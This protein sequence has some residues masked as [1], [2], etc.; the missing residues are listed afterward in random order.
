VLN[1]LPLGQDIKKALTEH[2]GWLYHA[3]EVC[4][5]FERG[6]WDS[7]QEICKRHDLDFNDMLQAYSDAIIWSEQRLKFIA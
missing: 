1:N 6:D 7:M 3:I 5:E 4:F 2:E